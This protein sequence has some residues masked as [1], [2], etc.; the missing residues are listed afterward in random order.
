MRQRDLEV[1][2]L[3]R[4]LAEETANKLALQAGFQRQLAEETANKLALQAGFQRQLAEEMANK[5]ALQAALQR[6]LADKDAEIERLRST[7]MPYTSTFLKFN[8][9]FSRTRQTDTLLQ[10]D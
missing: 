1:I 8:L 2:A 9:A 7:M 5:L 10:A 6:Q 3:Q 4:Q